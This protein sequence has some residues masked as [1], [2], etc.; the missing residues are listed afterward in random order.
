M[1]LFVAVKERL[2]PPIR[3]R[4]S[5]EKKRQGLL[6]WPE[7]WESVPPILQREVEGHRREEAAQ[8]KQT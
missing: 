8:V 5:E 4:M 6:R 2:T 3:Q 1:D 7:W